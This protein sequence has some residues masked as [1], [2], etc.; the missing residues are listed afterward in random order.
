[1]LKASVSFPDVNDEGDDDHDTC[2]QIKSSI[3]RNTC[4]FHLKVR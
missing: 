3:S 2:G 1:M 4:E